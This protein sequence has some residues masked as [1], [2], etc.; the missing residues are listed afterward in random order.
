M[1]V[2]IAGSRH[3]PFS[4]YDLIQ[5]AIT[6]SG[7]N[8]EEVV[9]GQ[10]PGADTYGAKWA[11][12]NKIPIKNFPAEWSKYGKKAGPIRNQQMADY[13][14]A[15]IVFIW[16]GSR[17]SQDMLSRMQKMGKPVYVVR[18]GEL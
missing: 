6:L 14:D 2:I 7:F 9:C 1:K 17:G 10:A 18:N 12:T 8:V 11:Y 15:L 3:M 4:K 16:N 5:K 13:A